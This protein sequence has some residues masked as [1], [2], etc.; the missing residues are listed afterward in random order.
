[1]SRKHNWNTCYENEI[2]LVEQTACF[3][4]LMINYVLRSQHEAERWGLKL[5]GPDKSP[6]WVPRDMNGTTDTF[7]DG[8]DGNGMFFASSWLAIDFTRDLSRICGH[9]MRLHF[10]NSCEG[11]AG[12]LIAFADG[13]C[14]QT[15]YDAPGE[16]PPWLHDRLGNHPCD[17]N[18][19]TLDAP[20]PSGYWGRLLSETEK[21]R[22]LH[23]LLERRTAS[24]G[25]HG[26][27]PAD[28][29]RAFVRADYQTDSTEGRLYVPTNNGEIRPVAFATHEERSE[30]PW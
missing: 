13:T 2:T 5:R 6:V 16:A 27:S 21:E 25:L 29:R 28:L 23:L 11:L 19:L 7:I 1:M 14:C 24:Q 15:V 22:A 18:T 8:I 9:D 17:E 10:A 3:E 12:E 4:C 26:L 20:I 30:K